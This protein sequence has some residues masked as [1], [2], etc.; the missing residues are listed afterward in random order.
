VRFVCCKTA[1]KITPGSVAVKRF[2]NDVSTAHVAARRFGVQISRVLN[3]LFCFG[4]IATHLLKGIRVSTNFSA[5][6]SVSIA[7]CAKSRR[8]QENSAGKSSRD[9]T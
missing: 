5:L 8:P 2:S 4:N 6:H 9:E 7:P 3:D 1:R